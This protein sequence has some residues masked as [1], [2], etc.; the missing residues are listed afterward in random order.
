MASLFQRI[1]YRTWGVAACAVTAGLMAPGAQAATFQTFVNDSAGFLAAIGPGTVVQTE[2]FASAVDMQPVAAAA[3]A[4][5]VWNGF[6]VQ[7]IGPGTGPY[8]PS[9]YC[10]SLNSA[11]CISW[12]VNAPAVP[13]IYGAFSSAPD[14][15]LSIKPASSTIAGFSFDFSDW[16]DFGQ[17]SQF[18]VLASDGT[19]TL[20]T[21]PSNP[22]GAPPMSFGVTLSP[23]DIAAGRYVTEIRWLGLPGQSE[24]VGFYNFKVYT[25]PVLTSPAAVPTLSGWALLLLSAGMA[26]GL[27]LSRRRG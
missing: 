22:A 23:A 26:G 15:G 21:G 11:S 20:V 14:A 18:E 6:T 12:N 2:D 7:V 19:S 16:N 10:A 25:N 27:A 17:R 9:R 8:Q 24:V 4:P 13:G 3:A 5:D 1:I